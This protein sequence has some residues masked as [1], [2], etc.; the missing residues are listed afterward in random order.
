MKI[1]RILSALLALVLCT[2]TFLGLIPGVAASTNANTGNLANSNRFYYGTQGRVNRVVSASELFKLLFDEEALGLSAAEI[3]YLNENLYS[4]TYNDT[5]PKETAKTYY[6]RQSEEESGVLTVTIPKYT[7]PNTQNAKSAIWVPYQVTVAGAT[8]PLTEWNETQSAYVCRFT[9]EELGITGLEEDDTDLDMVISFRLTI[10]LE[11]DAIEAL[12]TKSK[13]DGENAK[14]KLDDHA[15]ALQVY[16]DKLAARE[17]WEDEWAAWKQEWDQYQID[18]A[19]FNTYQTQLAKYERDLEKYNEYL[20]ALEEYQTKKQAYE[21]YL[22]AKNAYDQAWAAY[23]KNQDDWDQYYQNLAS[24]N[25][26]QEKLAP[27][28]KRLDVMTKMFVFDSNSRQLFNAI[29]GDLV[30]SILYDG[31]GSEYK[32]EYEMLGLESVVNKAGLAAEALRGTDRCSTCGTKNCNKHSGTVFVPGYLV[33]FQIARD[34]W[35]NADAATKYE[36]FCSMYDFYCDHYDD[37]KTNFNNLFDALYELYSNDVIVDI[38]DGEG[39]S[40]RFMQFLG[41]LYITT[42]CFDDGT[43]PNGGEDKTWDMHWYPNE[44]FEYNENFSGYYLQNIVQECHFPIDTG[45]SDPDARYLGNEALTNYQLPETEVKKPT[46]PYIRL[47]E[48]TAPAVV[49]DPSEDEPEEVTE[50]TEPTVVTDP[51][52]APIEPTE[53]PHPGQEPAAPDLSDTMVAWASAYAAVDYEERSEQIEARSLTFETTV[54]RQV[55]ISNKFFVTF[56]NG[57]EEIGSQKFEESTT[58]GAVRPSVDPTREPDERYYYTFIGWETDI[59]TPLN[60][61]TPITSDM[62]LYAKYSTTD[63][64]YQVTWNV[65]GAPEDYDLPQPPK[66]QYKYEE[67]PSYELEDFTFGDYEYVFKGWTPKIQKVT[68]DVT[69]TGTY[70]RSLR[71]FN[72]TWVLENGNR[73]VT[74]TLLAGSVPVYSG[75]MEYVRELVWYRFSHWD[76]EVTEIHGDV[77]YTAIYREDAFSVGTNGA[78]NVEMEVDED[79]ITVTMLSSTMNFGVIAEYAAALDADLTIQKGD[80][81]V[82]LK[83]SALE[84]LTEKK[85]AQIKLGKTPQSGREGD[86]YVLNFY[87]SNNKLL[88]TDVTSKIYYRYGDLT[89]AVAVCFQKSGADWKPVEIKR[90]AGVMRFDAVGGGTYWFASEYYL[91]HEPVETCNTTSLPLRALAG[92]WIDLSVISCVKG[93][94]I[95]GAVLTYADGR[96]ETVSATGFTMPAESVSMKLCVEQI[97][98][99]VSFVVDGVVIDT[100]EYF[101]GDAIVVPEDP[102]LGKDDG[103]VYS[104]IG[105]S[106]NVNDLATGEERDIVYQAQFKA[107]QVVGNEEMQHLSTKSVDHLIYTVIVIAAIFVLLVI[108]IIIIAVSKA[109]KRK[110]E[111]TWSRFD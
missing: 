58:L 108:V 104:F 82:L 15:A 18:K 31:E 98:Y 43:Y 37:L 46:Q 57:D 86:Y 39:R 74:D 106:P 73:I 4:L 26:F 30:T 105:W 45:Y 8:K 64:F 52:T 17:A 3:A 33:D 101:L 36:K 19:K 87:D 48:P 92:A 13:T 110:S 77:T 76:K 91:R 103:F 84:K 51:G 16:R 61:D 60:D 9:D 71:E 49:E 72:V 32:K 40:E 54:S 53:V 59:G 97:V 20:D 22:N 23:E 27:A 50:P 75:S 5:I 81:T 25:A 35:K 7:T 62:T 88:N 100:K 10:D 56:F 55:S 63:R 90:Q 70:E 99:R 29:T 107:A 34:Q 11:E 21:A 2:G 111:Y 24:Y 65:V 95:T 47:T 41:Q 94:E 6:D 89:D 69:Y 67:M 42:R 79:S 44:E 1:K 83:G 66:T 38:I 78:T 14:R 68:G 85:C 93:Y 80:V 12:L 109:R 102:T 28:E 96:E